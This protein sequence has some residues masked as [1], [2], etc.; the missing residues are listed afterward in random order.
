M[1]CNSCSN[2]TLPGVHGPQG[3]AGTNG[4]PGDDGNGI[5]SIAWTSNSSGS[6]QGTAG[7]TD[8]YT[9][10]YDDATTNTF[11]VT[12][13]ANGTDGVALIYALTSPSSDVTTSG[14]SVPSGVSI[15]TI[16]AGMLDTNEDTIRLEGIVF[17]DHGDVNQGLEISISQPSLVATQ[18]GLGIFA[19]D[20][21][22]TG[23]YG[24]KFSVDITR[25][26]N[27]SV[28]IKASNEVMTD[29]GVA[30][31][32]YLYPSNYITGYFPIKVDVA[33]QVISG[34]DLD[35]EDLTI[36]L[37]LKTSNSSFPTKISELKIFLIKKQ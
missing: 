29:I 36:D 18:L 15:P 17:N 9:I 7:T 16:A 22:Y 13:G 37:K 1:S 24:Y 20:L 35:G 11:V 8:T 32:I 28:R 14:Y 2:I 6:P 21:L 25:V 34:T 3:P 27:T 31:F 4:A 33:N 5:A 23:A 26:S 10:T 30:S 12:N 19:P